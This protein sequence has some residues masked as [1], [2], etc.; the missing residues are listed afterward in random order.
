MNE[1]LKKF[2]EAFNMNDEDRAIRILKEYMQKRVYLNIFSENLLNVITRPVNGVPDN[3]A[4][5]PNAFVTKNIPKKNKKL[6]SLK[7]NV[8]GTGLAPGAWHGDHDSDG[9]GDG[10]GDGE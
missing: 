5:I 2:L 6:P 4:K 10:G 3:G 1:D 7:K 9:G 8:Y